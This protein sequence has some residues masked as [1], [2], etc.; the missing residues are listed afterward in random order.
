[1]QKRSVYCC[2]GYERLCR[3]S[4]YLVD[5]RFFAHLFF[6]ATLSPN[7]VLYTYLPMVN[8]HFVVLQN[9]IALPHCNFLSK[10]LKLQWKLHNISKNSLFAIDIS[11][12]F[13]FDINIALQ[14]TFWAL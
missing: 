4:K 11:Q 3:K 8:V 9:H 2:F 13:E 10:T 6:S 7:D 12:H 14:E 1:M 5:K